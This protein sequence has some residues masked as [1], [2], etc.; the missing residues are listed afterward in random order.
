MSM[1]KLAVTLCGLLG[2]IVCVAAF[3]VPGIF[4]SHLQDP[5]VHLAPPRALGS[6]PPEPN[7]GPHQQFP[8]VRAAIESAR[9]QRTEQADTAAEKAN[10][11]EETDPADLGEVTVPLALVD[12]T[13]G[14]FTTEEQLAAF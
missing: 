12:P 5:P 3:Y 8:R 2:L 14:C 7:V 13:D 1:T 6:I 11:V 9:Q 4:V 10:S